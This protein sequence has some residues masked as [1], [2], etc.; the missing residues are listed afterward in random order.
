MKLIHCA[1]LHLDSKLSENLDTEKAR[2]RRGE[3][4]ASFTKMVEYA[5]RENAAGILISGDMFDRSNISIQAQNTVYNTI[6]N[7]P[8][9]MFFYLKGNHDESSFLDSY[10]TFPDNLKLFNDKEFKIYSLGNKVKIAGM[11]LNDNSTIGL[12]SKLNLSPDFINIV[13][14]H[15]DAGE[16][17]VSDSESMINLRSFSGKNVKY[18]ALGHIHSY[19]VMQ[20]DPATKAV[21]PGVLEARGFDECGE[22]GFVLLD[23]D[24]ANMT[25]KDTFVP[26]MSRRYEKVSV[27][28]SECGISNEIAHKISDEL[29]S[30]GLNT[31]SIVKVDL[32]GTVDV[33]CEK[34]PEYIYNCLK[35]DYFVLKI[36]DKS[37]YKVSYERFLYEKS[38]KGSFVRM[39]A[40]DDTLDDER[41]AAIIRYGL[42]AISGEGVEECD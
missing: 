24:E 4:L 7:N 38:L 6:L 28:I 19:K 39:V 2:I 34:N 30:R 40:A 15:A 5:V 17:I 25:V 20:I 10:D 35:D 9:I 22:H 42:M 27:D 11:E 29:K 1:D 41:K 8:S 21:Y 33:E 31:D 32:V 3:I 13:M 18:M 14:L 37:T 12:A 16:N 26:F 36:E 23:I